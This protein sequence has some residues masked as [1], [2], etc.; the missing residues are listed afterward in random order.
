MLVCWE[1]QF[2]TPDTSDVQRDFSKPLHACIDTEREVST[3]LS[4]LFVRLHLSTFGLLTSFK[5]P[6]FTFFRNFLKCLRVCE[7]RLYVCVHPVWGECLGKGACACMGLKRRAH[8]DSRKPLLRPVV[9]SPLSTAVSSR[10]AGLLCGVI[11]ILCLRLGDQVQPVASQIWA[12]LARI[13]RG[14]PPANAPPGTAGQ[15]SCSASESITNDAL[16]ATSA[17]V[18]ASGPST[19]AFAEDIVCI[20]ASG[21]ENSTG[22]AAGS[23]GGGAGAA[24]ATSGSSTTDELQTV[25]ICVELVGDVSRALGPAFAPYS[26][27][28]LARMYQMLQDPNV[29][30]ALKPCVMVAVGDAAMTMGG[31][32]FAPYLDSFMAILHQAGNTTYDVGPSNWQV[33]EEWLWY[34]HDLREGVLQAYMSIVYSFKEKCM[35]EQLKLYVNAMLDVVKAVAATSPKMRGVDENVK[36]AIELVGDLISTYGGD[37]TLHLQRAPFMEQ[38]LQLAQVLGTVKD[39]GGEACLQKAQWLRQLMARYS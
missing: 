8:A 10:F 29:E 12:C 30:R 17:L 21:L 11:Q 33:N 3:Y 18:N 25:R 15:L 2:L 24:A 39:A 38:L 13:F 14:S 22:S 5:R 16:L 35:Q 19:A 26:S 7:Y 9:E 23:S 1:R 27:P 20:I 34:I 28:L 6:V 32:A 37:L 4:P 36:Q 31:E